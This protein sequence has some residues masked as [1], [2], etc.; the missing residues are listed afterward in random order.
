MA[1]RLIC[2]LTFLALPTAASASPFGDALPDQ[3]L[4]KMRGGFDL[5]NG[6]NVALGVTTETRVDG[7]MILRTVLSADEGPASISTY[8]RDESGQLVAVQLED[9]ATVIGRDGA[10]RLVDNRGA[11][12]VVLDGQQTDVTH[13]LGDGLGSLVANTAD[14]RTIDVV[15]TVDVD[16]R[17]ASPDLIG[18]SLFRVEGLALDATRDLVR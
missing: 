11:V 7:Q 8:A 6:L 14:G 12:R 13:L 16:V 15:T 10:V 3:S 2:A 1:R 17:N 18:S 9:G 5:P 4:D